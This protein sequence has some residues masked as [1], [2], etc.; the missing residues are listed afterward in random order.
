MGTMHSTRTSEMFQFTADRTT[1]CFINDGRPA[2]F[3]SRRS[4]TSTLR[5]HNKDVVLRPTGGIVVF[6]TS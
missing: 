5:H 3:N 4:T 1:L 6:T 2:P